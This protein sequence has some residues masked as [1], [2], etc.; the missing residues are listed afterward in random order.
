[1]SK[2][3]PFFFLKKKTCLCIKSVITQSFLE[4]MKIKEMMVCLYCSQM[5]IWTDNFLTFSKI[6]KWIMF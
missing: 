6:N 1:M 4:I 3:L 5:S 2:H